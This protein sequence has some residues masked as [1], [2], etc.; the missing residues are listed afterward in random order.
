MRLKNGKFADHNL[1]KCVLRPWPWPREGLSLKS[2]SLALTSFFFESLALNVVSST[3]SLP[4]ATM[5]K[6]Q[7]ENFIAEQGTTG[8]ESLEEVHKPQKRLRTTDLDICLLKNVTA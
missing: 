5:N 2:R 3:L 6:I 4:V 1:E 7:T 8:V